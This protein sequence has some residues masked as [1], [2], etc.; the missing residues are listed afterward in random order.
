[1]NGQQFEKLFIPPWAQLYAVPN[2]Y[3]G[4]D[5]VQ[6]YLSRIHSSYNGWSQTGGT[7]PNLQFLDWSIPVN[8]SVWDSLATPT[9]AEAL[10]SKLRIH[11]DATLI[12]PP[13]KGLVV[14]DS[15][16]LQ[17]TL[18]L[19]IRSGEASSGCL[20]DS[21]LFVFDSIPNTCRYERFMFGERFH[22]AGA[23]VSNGT[24][25]LLQQQP[26][27]PNQFFRWNE[28][29]NEWENLND[30][31][32][33]ATPLDVARGYRIKYAGSAPMR[34]FDGNFSSGPIHIPISYTPAPSGGDGWNLVG[35]P[36][37]SAIFAARP[38]GGN[39]FIEQN[40]SIW[41]SLY[42]YDGTAP[43]INGRTDYAVYNLAGAVR[44]LENGLI[45]NG[46]IAPGQ[47]FF[48]KAYNANT[49]VHFDNNMRTGNNGLFFKRQTDPQQILLSLKNSENDYNEILFSFMADATVD[50]DR[51]LDA[52]KLKGNS[53]LSLYSLINNEGFVIQSNPTLSSNDVYALPL[54]FETAVP[55]QHVM[56]LEWFENIPPNLYILLED[57]VTGMTV[58]LKDSPEYSFSVATS[59]VF[60]NRFILHITPYLFSPALDDS[61]QDLTVFS[62]NKTVTFIYKGT[63]PMDRI[64]LF[65]ISGKEIVAV[66][67]RAYQVSIDLHQIPRQVVFY[68]CQTSRSVLR[69]KILLE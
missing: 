42:F 36:Y 11:P 29:L 14:S 49:E 64:R 18:C 59:G 30:G 37:P 40:D 43:M 31:E 58:N 66:E 68:S 52:P 12:I 19:V 10:I 33:P 53:S 17:D 3:E 47:G 22:D 45:S 41:G 28:P 1:M 57:L 32:D 6:L 15:A 62:K 51:L 63:D 46:V 61:K 24:Y 55:G 34:N 23:P 5:F 69:G 27:P 25:A 60:L 56:K 13:G 39:D 9:A 20:L 48:V 38:G 21:D 65:D 7:T 44:G 26:S 8:T 35:N 4:T 50:P 67:A 2:I 16:F 54:G